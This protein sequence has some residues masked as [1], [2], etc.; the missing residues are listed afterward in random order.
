[1]ARPGDISAGLH[2]EELTRFDRL[3]NARLAVEPVDTTDFERPSRWVAEYRSGLRADDA[4]HV[5]VCA[6]LNA[7]FYAADAALARAAAEFGVVVRRV[8]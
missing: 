1:M 5:A 2:E 8:A 7:R 3:T 6:R 4:L